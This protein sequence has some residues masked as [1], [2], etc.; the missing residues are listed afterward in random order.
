MRLSVM[1]LPVIRLFIAAVCL[2]A[3]SAY[4]VDTDPTLRGYTPADSATEIGW[5]QKLRAM[6]EPDRIR[7]NM[8]RLSARP[9]HVGSPY[10][11]DNAEW[12][13]IWSDPVNLSTV[14]GWFL[15]FREQGEPQ[16]GQNGRRLINLIFAGRNRRVMIRR[17]LPRTRVASPAGPVA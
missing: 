14:V 11:K 17:E 5:E 8:R 7:E 12:L 16:A 9:H 13:L 15:F 2:F 1:R 6:P 4:A 10:D 3:L